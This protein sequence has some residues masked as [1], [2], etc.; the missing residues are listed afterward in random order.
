MLRM[1]VLPQLDKIARDHDVGLFQWIRRIF[2]SEPT[3]CVQESTE[4]DAIPLVFGGL[5]LRSAERIATQHI[6]PVGPIVC[7]C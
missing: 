5:G 3:Q 7:R 4:T 1:S 2:Q 6:R